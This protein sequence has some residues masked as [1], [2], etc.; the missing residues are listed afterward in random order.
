MGKP[1]AYAI[2]VRP[3]M[4]RPGPS[5]DRRR[6]GCRTRACV[7][8]GLTR[9]GTVNRGVYPLQLFRFIVPADVFDSSGAEAL[10]VLYREHEAL[11]RSIAQYR[12]RIPA[13]DAEALVHDVFASFLERRPEA[14]DPKAFLVGAINNAS[15]HY[16]RKRQ[17]EAPLLPEHEMTVSGD[18]AERLERW[19]LR[20]SLGATLARLGGKCSETLRRY[21]LRDESAETI[22]EQLDTSAAYVWQLLSSCRKR[23]RQIY[24]ALTTPKS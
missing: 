1:A 14:F 12:Y 9:R 3:W 21:Y 15:R 11:L 10:E 13:A 22:A 2:T 23:A 16:W 5:S 19:T 4:V 6:C 20:I 8:R 24:H 7:Q 18:E 17:H